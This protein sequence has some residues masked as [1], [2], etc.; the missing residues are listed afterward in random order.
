M[1]SDP[2]GRGS[3]LRSTIDFP[4]AARPLSRKEPLHRVIEG[5]QDAAPPSPRSPSWILVLLVLLVLLVV[6]N[7]RSCPSW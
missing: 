7:P 6:K 1:R 3:V 2:G 5:R 4:Q